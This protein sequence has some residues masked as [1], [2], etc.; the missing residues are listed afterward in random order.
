MWAMGVLLYFMLVGLTPFKGETLA[1]LKEVILMFNPS[2]RTI[3]TIIQGN[4]TI[5]D[6]V[7]FSAS[8]LIKCLLEMEPEKRLD[9]NDVK[10][11]DPRTAWKRTI[12]EESL[13]KRLSVP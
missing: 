13:A 3:Q 10:V 7:S 12:I 2:Q 6:Y 1:D 8:N 11:G 5:P 9:V 4:Y